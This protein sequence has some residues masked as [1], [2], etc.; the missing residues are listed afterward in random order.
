MPEAQDPTVALLKEWLDRT[1]NS[2]RL[3]YEAADYR[4][5][6]HFWLGVPS[7]VLSALVAAA[8]LATIAKENPLLGRMVGT[9]S[10]V[11]AILA[12]L[13]TF[14]KFG[15]KAEKHRSAGAG[16]ADAGREI[17]LLLTKIDTKAANQKLEAIKK[18]FSVIASH[19]PVTPPSIA[20]R[21]EARQMAQGRKANL[22]EQALTGAVT[23]SD[24]PAGS[25]D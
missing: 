13:Q 25:R 12:G 21:F 14:L 15:E 17:E 1:Q 8:V 2:S 20:R 18:T 7:V 19:A 16:Y 4:A 3:Q 5:S 9:L 22:C 24:R 10:L 6:Q 23:H 11:A